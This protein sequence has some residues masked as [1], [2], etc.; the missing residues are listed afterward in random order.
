MKR[1][2]VYTA[3]GAVAT[4]TVVLA[5]SCSV[6]ALRSFGV[7]PYPNDPRS[8]AQH[9]C[10]TNYVEG[11]TTLDGALEHYEVPMPAS[12]TAVRFYLDPGAFDG[13]DDFYLKFSASAAQIRSFLTAL[14]AKPSG[15]A[16]AVPQSEVYDGDIVPWTFNS[17][18]ATY[19]F[20]KTIGPA[21]D[22]EYLLG[23]VVVPPG[24]T[25]AY[26]TVED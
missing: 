18:D 11:A 8:Y 23:G 3:L 14:G 10:S 21:S 26:V 1:V 19:A 16:E 5:A 22:R 4:T 7:C 13:G 17:S 20:T 15:H 2:V 25:T 24:M 6:Q 12:A 9:S